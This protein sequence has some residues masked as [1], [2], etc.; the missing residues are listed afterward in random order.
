MS[1]PGA[2]PRPHA[3]APDEGRRPQRVAL[4]LLPL[5]EA[6]DG[7]G[8]GPHPLLHHHVLA[9]TAPLAPAGAGQGVVPGLLQQGHGHRRAEAEDFLITR[10]CHCKSAAVSRWQ[11]R[12]CS[13]HKTCKLWCCQY[14]N[15]ICVCTYSSSSVQ[16]NLCEGVRGTL[17]A[18]GAPPAPPP[19]VPRPPAH[20][21]SPGPAHAQCRP[22][23]HLHRGVALCAAGAGQ[24]A[25]V[26]PVPGLAN[27][28]TR[29]I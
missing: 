27:W 1:G 22:P 14:Y 2:R 21:P 11:H 20:R 23:G 29:T 28:A 9:A 7:A 3:G 15:S 26:P 16:Y 19:E 24:A 5:L 10:A 12:I 25:A 6:V 8:G 17:A 13:G 4:P 18:G